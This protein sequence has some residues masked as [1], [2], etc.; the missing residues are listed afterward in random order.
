MDRWT[1]VHGYP[2]GEAI[3]LDVRQLGGPG[4]ASCAGLLRAVPR[5]RPPTASPDAAG[6]GS[7]PQ[8]PSADA[9]QCFLD[10]DRVSSDSEGLLTPKARGELLLQALDPP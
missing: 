7:A 3:W 2:A 6:G 4:S 10:D 5:C 9:D 8:R 1:P